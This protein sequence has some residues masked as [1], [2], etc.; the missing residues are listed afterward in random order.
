MNVILAICF[1]LLWRYASHRNRLL[2]KDADP[3]GIAAI[4]RQYVF[5]PFVYMVTFGL[6]WISVPACIILSLLIALFFAVP[7]F[8][9]RLPSKARDLAPL[10]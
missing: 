1:N 8:S 5:G 3:I 10:Q 7:G 9:P 4:S 2:D 6:A